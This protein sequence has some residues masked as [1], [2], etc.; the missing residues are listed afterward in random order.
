MGMKPTQTERLIAD[1]P[2]LPLPPAEMQTVEQIS[3]QYWNQD[4]NPSSA[5]IRFLKRLKRKY[6]KE[7]AP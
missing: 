6:E 4:L 7:T 2:A 1:C 3:H 5:E